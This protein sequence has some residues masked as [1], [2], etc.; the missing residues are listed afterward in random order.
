MYSSLD[1]YIP[2]KKVLLYHM[3]MGKKSPYYSQSSWQTRIW[4]VL[5]KWPAVYKMKDSQDSFFLPSVQWNKME[6]C[7]GA[8]WT[9]GNAIKKVRNR[10]NM[11]VSQKLELIISVS[12]YNV[13]KC[14]LWNNS[15]PVPNMD[16]EFCLLFGFQA[17]IDLIDFRKSIWR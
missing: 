15:G 3:L 10:R 17:P 5:M 16:S 4:K 1:R 13:F 9:G 14:L 8:C 6:N 7:T 11:F 2:G 12:T